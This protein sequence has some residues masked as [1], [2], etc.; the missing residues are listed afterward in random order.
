MILP[1]HFM[2]L[3]VLRWWYVRMYE[4]RSWYINVGPLTTLLCWW[5]VKGRFVGDYTMDYWLCLDSTSKHSLNA[6]HVGCV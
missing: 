5:C 4:R 1:I 2:E 3:N 6:D